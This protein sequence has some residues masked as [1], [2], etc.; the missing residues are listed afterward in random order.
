MTARPG[1][2]NRL[3]LIMCSKMADNVLLP[4]VQVARLIGEKPKGTAAARMA[5]HFTDCESC[6]RPISTNPGCRKR[7]SMG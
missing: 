5:Y 7:A 4:S 2:L 3:Q 6:T 1:R